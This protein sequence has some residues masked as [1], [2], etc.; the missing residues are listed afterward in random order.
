M[1]HVMRAADRRRAASIISS[2][3]SMFSAGG[4]VGWTM[5]T[6]DP[7]MFSSMRTKISPSAKARRGDA[8]RSTPMQCAISRRAR[9]CRA[10]EEL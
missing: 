2:S 8:V 10:G 6:S 1:T 3:S 7:R 4:L 9:G 5:N